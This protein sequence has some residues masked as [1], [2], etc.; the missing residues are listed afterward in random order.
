MRRTPLKRTPIARPP[1]P[2]APRPRLTLAVIDHD[3]RLALAERC[4]LLC[5][6]CAERRPVAGFHAHHR[7]LRAQGGPDELPNLLALHGFCHRRAHSHVRWSYAH[8]FLV[9]ST[10]N[11]LRRPVCLGLSRWVLLSPAGTYVD[12]EPPDDWEPTA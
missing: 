5:D 2:P 6:L 10:D 9:R 8:G 1:W 7:L 11:P 3:L 4:G 12:T